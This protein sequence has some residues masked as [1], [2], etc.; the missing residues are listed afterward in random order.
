MALTIHRF[1]APHG[2]IQVQTTAGE[3]V[4]LVD[5]GISYGNP[6]AWALIDTD[7]EP[8][9]VS[10]T[11]VFTGFS[12]TTLLEAGFEVVGSTVDTDGLVYHVLVKIEDLP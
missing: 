1:K 9:K 6:C 11:S 7:A 5:C 2:E 10:A 4:K 8:A 3:L 12:V